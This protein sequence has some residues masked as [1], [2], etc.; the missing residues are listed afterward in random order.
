VEKKFFA[1]TGFAASTGKG[2]TDMTKTADYEAG[3][4]NH[5]KVL[6]INPNEKI[7]A[8]EAQDRFC[9]LMEKN[10]TNQSP[11][12]RQQLG[13][14]QKLVFDG[15]QHRRD[16]QE[17]NTTVEAAKAAAEHGAVSIKTVPQVLVLGQWGGVFGAGR[18]LPLVQ[19]AALA[20]TSNVGGG[21][22]NLMRRLEQE[23]QEMQAKG[24]R[25]MNEYGHA[26]GVLHG[27]L[28]ERGSIAIKTEDGKPWK[29][30]VAD[31]VQHLVASDSFKRGEPT[32][33]GIHVEGHIMMVSA[34]KDK[35]DQ[36]SF[37]FY[38]PNIGVT[39]FASADKLTNFMDH[40]F[41]ELGMGKAY[42]ALSKSG[43]MKFSHVEVIDVNAFR[44][45]K[46]PN[47]PELTSF[48][49]PKP[50]TASTV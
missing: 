47:I 4:A 1:L 17:L 2:A 7:S 19:L 46:V 15:L 8:F 33:Y 30:G 26:L 39:R 40:F 49:A 29:P 41:V 12:V 48:I 36:P 43:E 9:T 25:D 27:A 16:V 23:T 35:D 5:I 24:S 37:L 44:T 13:A 11:E 18:C 14:L 38:D 50:V 22:E 34:T 28:K 10:P 6:G 45:I 31:T 32:S 3:Y 21:A 42:K 20:E